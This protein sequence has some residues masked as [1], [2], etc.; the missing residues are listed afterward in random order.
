MNGELYPQAIAA[1]IGDKY[2]MFCD[3]SSPI[4]WIYENSLTGHV[5]KLNA[6]YTHVLKTV[7]DSPLISYFYCLGTREDGSSF[8]AKSRLYVAGKS[9]EVELMYGS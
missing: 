6:T 9:V 1:S 4:T 8:H 7:R 3:S 2:S 5:K